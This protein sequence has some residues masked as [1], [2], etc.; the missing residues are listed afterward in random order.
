MGVGDGLFVLRRAQTVVKRID[1][2]GGGD[3]AVVGPLRVT[4]A[5]GGG[6]AQFHVNPLTRLR[7]QDDRILGDDERGRVGRDRRATS[8]GG[9]TVGLRSISSAMTRADLL[10]VVGMPSA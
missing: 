1:E 4:V 10:V 6:L 5:G 8:L 9:D 2:V 7:L 3:R